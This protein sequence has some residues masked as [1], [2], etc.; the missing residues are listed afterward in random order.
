VR[1]LTQIHIAI[2]S[3][4]A[5]LPSVEAR[6]EFRTYVVDVGSGSQPV[7]E[8]TR[9]GITDALAPNMVSRRAACGRRAGGWG[10]GRRRGVEKGLYF[11][12]LPTVVNDTFLSVVVNSTLSLGEPL[13]RAFSWREK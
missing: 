3:D 11:S 12:Y 7:H 6:A 8:E 9:G 13:G 5:P 4:E 2:D 10:E 1:E